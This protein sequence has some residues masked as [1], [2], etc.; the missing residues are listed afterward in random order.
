MGI[1]RAIVY[2][3][4][5]CGQFHIP[6]ASPRRDRG[7][8]RNVSGVMGPLPSVTPASGRALARMGGIRPPS[9]ERSGALESQGCPLLPTPLPRRESGGIEPRAGHR[10][11]SSQ[12]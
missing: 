8:G 7:T 6:G 12:K 1:L 2:G 9:A 11:G 10:R 5:P 3:R 4:R